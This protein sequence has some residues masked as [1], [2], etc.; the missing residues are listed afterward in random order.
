VL[1]LGLVLRVVPRP[2]RLA[3][4]LV[5]ALLSSGALKRDALEDWR[6]AIAVARPLVESPDTP[7]LVRSGLPQARPEKFLV[8]PEPA[9]L[10]LAPLA[11]YR[12]PGTPRLL[13]HDLDEDY[14]RRVIVPEIESHSRILLVAH[15]F[16]VEH[17]RRTP[18]DHGSTTICRCTGRDGSYGYAV[19]SWSSMICVAKV[20]SA[21]QPSDLCRQIRLDAFE[22]SLWVHSK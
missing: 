6:G 8:E 9:G 20:N 7:V 16:D 19:W 15:D 13:P 12:M 14:L 1:A 18:L 17:R 3:L 22:V 2:V 5:V 10:I 21:D 4:L 11:L